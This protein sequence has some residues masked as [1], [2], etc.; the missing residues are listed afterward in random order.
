MASSIL[1]E[2]V[3]DGTEFSFHGLKYRVSLVLREGLNGLLYSSIM[4]RCFEG[5][6]LGAQ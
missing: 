5:N 3:F 2:P 1:F 6:L 4:E